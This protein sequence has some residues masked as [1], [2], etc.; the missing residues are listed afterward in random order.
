M[1]AGAI[2][3]E[4]PPRGPVLIAGGSCHLG[5]AL[6]AALIADGQ[7]VALTARDAAGAARIAA[8]LPEAAVLPLR[9]RGPD[10]GDAEED[11]AAPPDG[12][13]SPESLPERA[14][15]ALGT[16]PRG[17]VD[18][19]HSRFEALLPG[20]DPARIDLWAA[21]D[22]G[23]RARLLRAMSRSMLAA[24]DGRCVFVSST[25]AGR[26]APGQGYYAAAK[27]AG[28]ALYRAVGVELALRG[29]TACSLRLGCLEAGR[30]AT[31]LHAQPENPPLPPLGRI[32]TVAE[33]L[34]TLRFLLSAPASA[35]NAATLTCDGG[36][37][38][39]KPARH[40]GRDTT[41]RAS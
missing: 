7:A 28:E 3:Q 30:G 27:L 33:A 31:F 40:P 16:A 1:V 26:A 21:C 2:G 20:A 36:F 13:D 10:R 17:F 8:A 32:V 19:L 22:I 37:A 14:R 12:D 9:A 38:A 41:P 24:R 39:L 6:G 15:A 18:M 11:R 35:I 4:S 25:A 29:V 23:F 34:H 5:L